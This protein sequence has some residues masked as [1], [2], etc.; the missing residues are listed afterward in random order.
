MDIKQSNHI[1]MLDGSLNLLKTRFNNHKDKNRFL[2]ILSPSCPLWRDQGARAVQETFLK[3]FPDANIAASIVWIQILNND[4]LEAAIPSLQYLSDK[5]FKH[6]YDEHQLVGKAIASSVGRQGHVA[7]DFYLF[8]EP[9]LTW[10]CMAPNP[11]YWM[12]QLKDS[13]ADK[14]HFHTAHNLLKELLN[15]MTQLLETA[16]FR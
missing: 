10:N 2:A 13:W 8:Y 15:A 7:W 3:H 1:T 4:S 11:T 9:Q 6:F 16:S 5:R 12:H 14:K